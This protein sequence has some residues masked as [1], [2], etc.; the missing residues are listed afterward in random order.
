MKEKDYLSGP[1]LDKCVQ[2]SDDAP[3]HEILRKIYFV[4]K[5]LKK[6]LNK[7]VE[8]LSALSFKKVPFLLIS[9]AAPMF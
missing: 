4:I 8:I 6:G 5:P 7:G 3:S 2:L 9:D 1:N